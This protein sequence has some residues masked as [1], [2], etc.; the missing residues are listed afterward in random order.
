MRFLTR[1]NGEVSEPLLGLKD[2]RIYIN[3]LSSNSIRK[4]IYDM[5]GYEHKRALRMAVGKDG[6]HKAYG[7]LSRLLCRKHKTDWKDVMTTLLNAEYAGNATY[8]WFDLVNAAES[9]D[10]DEYRHMKRVNQFDLI[11]DYDDDARTNCLLPLEYMFEHPDMTL[12]SIRKN[13]KDKA[14]RTGTKTWGVRKVVVYDGE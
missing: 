13:L 5:W 12:A 2:E 10:G 3:G 6:K 4:R 7:I 9:S 8:E 14:K 1:Y 11:V